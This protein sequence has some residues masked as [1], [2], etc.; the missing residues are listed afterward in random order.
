MKTLLLVILFSFTFIYAQKEFTLQEKKVPPKPSALEYEEDEDVKLYPPSSYYENNKTDTF[1][2][3]MLLQIYSE[4][5][6]LNREIINNYYYEREKR[7]WYTL[8]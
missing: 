6:K 7:K 3:F 1:E 8:H 2:Y 4:Q 5:R